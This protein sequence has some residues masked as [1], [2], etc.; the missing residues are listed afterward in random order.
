MRLPIQLCNY[1]ATAFICAV[2]SDLA[3]S[4]TSSHSAADMLDS[5]STSEGIFVSLNWILKTSTGKVV[6][7]KQQSDRGLGPKHRFRGKQK[8]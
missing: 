1:G 5:H 3:G 4:I 8:V 6:C 2:L 7:D